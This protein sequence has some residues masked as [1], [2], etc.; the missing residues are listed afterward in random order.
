MES[1]NASETNLTSGLVESEK[2]AAP[3]E[4]TDDGHRFVHAPERLISIGLAENVPGKRAEC[5]GP[6][7]IKKK[8]VVGVAVFFAEQAGGGFF[9]GATGEGGMN[10]S[11]GGGCEDDFPDWSHAV[12]ALISKRPSHVDKR[13][14]T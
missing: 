1:G 13:F 9:C 2:A 10:G 7:E 6:L 4:M 3:D 8:S 14:S 12:R 5:G 11:K